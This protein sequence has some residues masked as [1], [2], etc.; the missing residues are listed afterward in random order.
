MLALADAGLA[1]DAERYSWWVCLR[2]GVVL[3]APLELPAAPPPSAPP[4]LYARARLAA[5]MPAHVQLDS[6][7]FSWLN[8]GVDA[9]CVD[10][11]EE[12]CRLAFDTDAEGLWI[13]D[14]SLVVFPG[15]GE[16]SRAFF[17]AHFAAMQVAGCSA[18]FA[19]APF[20]SWV[21]TTSDFKFTCAMRAQGVGFTPFAARAQLSP[22]TPSNVQKELKL[23][24]GRV[25]PPTR[26]AMRCVGRNV[27]ARAD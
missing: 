4:S 7:H 10:G 18:H 20:W 13:A 3:Y 2:L 16:A 25:P 19:L 23:W 5:N 24:G 1:G 17:N 14:D 12:G 21:E 26:T 8:T 11:C 15:G 6:W 27:P 9:R 22:N